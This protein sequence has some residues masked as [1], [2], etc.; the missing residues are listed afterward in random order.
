MINLSILSIGATP[1]FLIAFQR[2]KSVAKIHFY[3]LHLFRLIFFKAIYS[4][5]PRS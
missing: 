4:T 5:V 2:K 3:Y 1:Q